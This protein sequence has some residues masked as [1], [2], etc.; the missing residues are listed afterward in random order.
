MDDRLRNLKKYIRPNYTLM[1]I[2]LAVFLF[3][4]FYSEYSRSY[5]V[6]I[7]W[8][9]IIAA[10]PVCELIKMSVLIRKMK[11]AGLLETMLDDFERSEL[12]AKGQLR[13]GEQYMFCKRAATMIA[14]DEVGLLYQQIYES[15]SR[16]SE[17]VLRAR[18]RNGK[19]RF[20]CKLRTSG[21]SDE[22]VQMI[23]AAAQKSNPN[24]RLD[25]TR[26]TTIPD[27]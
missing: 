21:E 17:R 1:L 25:E 10:K 23:L 15:A 13:M 2:G 27:D 14:Y 9:S 6:G 26:I 22:D 18:L 11:R 19:R 24:I 5:A 12:Y 20:L 3:T 8:G 4:V 16:E 7:F